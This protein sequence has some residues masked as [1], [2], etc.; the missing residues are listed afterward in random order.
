VLAWVLSLVGIPL[1]NTSP[2]VKISLEGLKRVLAKPTHKKSPFTVEILAA[3]EKKRNTLT[4]I[5]QETAC[6]LVLAGFLRFDEVA[7]ILL[8]DL[9]I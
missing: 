9:C 1:P 5:H 6:L 4:S 3:I 8:C 2:L 7:N